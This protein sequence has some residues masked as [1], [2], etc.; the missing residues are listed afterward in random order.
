MPEKKTTHSTSKKEVKEVKTTKTKKSD[1][2]KKASEIE[3]KAEK[4]EWQADKEVEKL[5]W[6]V[7]FVDK[8][9]NA[10][11]IK[12]IL[13][14][15]FIEKANKWVRKN[16]EII[17]KIL[18]IIWLIWWVISLIAWIGSLL[19]LNLCAFLW[20][21]ALAVFAILISRWCMKMRKR[22]PAIAII[23]ITL[24]IV[25]IIISIFAGW[26]WSA[27][28]STVLGAICTLFVLKNKDMF[29]N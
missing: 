25:R 10:S 17:C 26:F 6:K 21:L 12:E 8:I 5:V 24:G 15:S 2:E 27:F 9:I 11:W 18:W 1:L 28:V 16:L 7:E 4:L 13:N 20:Y 23:S 14:L 29:K 22:F 19:Q 3:K